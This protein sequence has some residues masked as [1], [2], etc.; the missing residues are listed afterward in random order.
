MDGFKSCDRLR[1][2]FVDPS[3]FE[4]IVENPFDPRPVARLFRGGQAVEGPALECAVDKILEL[5]APFASLTLEPEDPVRFYLELSSGE[6]SVDRTPREGIFE[7]TVP[8]AD[9]ENV[10][11]Q[12]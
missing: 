12:V 1:I 11:W 3:D 2:A 10:M 7:L 6:T 8:T 5:A 4:I 9:Y